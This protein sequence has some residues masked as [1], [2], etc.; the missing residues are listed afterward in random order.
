M[1]PFAEAAERA[2]ADLLV[3]LSHIE[4]QQ[5]QILRLLAELRRR[6]EAEYLDVAAL[7]KLLGI[8]SPA[9]RMR[10]KRG[11]TLLGIALRIDGKRVW[12]RTDVEMLIAKGGA[13]S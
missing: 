11:S 13:K 1:M 3:R 7:A 4:E 9:L 6:E 10:M 8:T 12:R 5:E 2:H